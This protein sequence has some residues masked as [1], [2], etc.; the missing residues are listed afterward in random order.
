MRQAVT[1]A[2]RNKW[3]KKCQEINTH[4][5][6]TRCKETWKFINQVKATQKKNTN[7]ELKKMEKVL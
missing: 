6:G 2:K 1:A 7:K 5:E 3:D 4:I